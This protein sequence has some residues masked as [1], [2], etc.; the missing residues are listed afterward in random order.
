MNGHVAGD[1]A[2]LE[3]LYDDLIELVRPMDEEALNRRPPVEGANTIAVLVRHIAGSLGMWCA[4]ALDEPFERDRDAEFR[5]HDAAPALVEALEVS[6]ATFRDQ[7]ARLEALE[8]DLA[9]PRT[10]DRLAGP[11]TVTAGWCLAHA[12]R[13]TGEHWGQIQLTRD[14]VLAG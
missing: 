14:L 3:E 2:I 9:A 1:V 8:V 11:L 10:V 6:R 5:A 12:V 7:L 4:R 13:H